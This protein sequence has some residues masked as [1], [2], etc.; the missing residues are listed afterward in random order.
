MKYFIRLM[1]VIISLFGIFGCS[2]PGNQPVAVDTIAEAVKS[3]VINDGK[4]HVYAFLGYVHSTYINSHHRDSSNFIINGINVGGIS[5]DECMFI[6]IPPGTYTFYFQERAP[7]MPAMT[8]PLTLDLKAD[9]NVF[10]AFDIFIGSKPAS[11]MMLGVA[12]GP[13]AVAAGSV[14]G[15]LAN[16]TVFDNRVV[17]KSEDGVKTIQGM[18]IILP[19]NVALERIQPIN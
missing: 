18:K 4:A 13:P 14:A 12:G 19:D 11:S 16:S 6:D 5:K 7:I 9:Q 2:L 17:D 15:A 1:M 3:G 8:K 10:L